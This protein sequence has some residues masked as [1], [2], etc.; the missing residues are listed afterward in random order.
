MQ[1]KLESGLNKI[2]HEFKDVLTA[3]EVREDKRIEY[4]DK[5]GDASSCSR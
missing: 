2:S 5:R 3:L 1:P 4:L